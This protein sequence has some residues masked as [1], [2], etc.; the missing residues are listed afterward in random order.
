MCARPH[1]LQY[2]YS[3][4]IFQFMFYILQSDYFRLVIKRPT[5]GL[6]E[7][8]LFEGVSVRIYS[9]IVLC[10]TAG[11]RPIIWMR[12]CIRCALFI[13][14]CHISLLSGYRRL[15]LP[16]FFIILS[17][18]QLQFQQGNSVLTYVPNNLLSILKYFLIIFVFLIF[19]NAVSF[20]PYV[21]ILYSVFSSRITSQSFSDT[22]PPYH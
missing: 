4:L 22:L 20:L 9:L 18:D 10:L 5:V 3:C 8:Q 13:P 6:A 17:L 16:L 14:S 12:V 21:S 2:T 19:S 7:N 1:E 11:P 15:R